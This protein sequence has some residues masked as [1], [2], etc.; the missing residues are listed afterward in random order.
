M[1][2]VSIEF[3][4]FLIITILIY[5]VLPKKAKCVWL[6][7]S[8]YAFYA[9]FDWKY[10]FLLIAITIINYVSGRVLSGH[11]SKAR[12]IL[13]MTIAVN[14][15]ILAFFKY[16]GVGLRIVGISNIFEDLILPVGISFYTFRVIS[17]LVDIYR[18]AEAEKNLVFFAL[19]VS[20]FPTVLEG[21][22]E[23]A[24][25]LI[26]QFRELSR[27]RLFS[28][29]SLFRGTYS[30]IL[31]YFIKMVIADRICFL[32]DAVFNDVVSNGTLMLIS[33]AIAY[34]IQIYTDFL[35]YSLIAMGIARIMGIDLV[36]NFSAP[37]L[38]RSIKDFWGR[39]HI[40]L[41]T[42]LKDYIYIPLGGSRCTK[43]RT[44][45]NLMATF[46]ISGIWHGA[47][48]K[49][50][51]WGFLHGVYQVIGRLLK[52]IKQI[53]YCGGEKEIFRNSGSLGFKILQTVCTFSLVS[54][55]WIFFRVQSLSEGFSFIFR[56]FTN[57]DYQKVAEYGIW[58]ENFELRD[59]V[60]CL[61]GLLIVLVVDIFKY[62]SH[63]TFDELLSHQPSIIRM[64][65]LLLLVG[66]TI[67]FGVYGL[68]TYTQ[69]FV[70][71][72]F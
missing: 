57:W 26:P 14:V 70:Y 25:H 45:F 27:R 68:G 42:W 51:F 62:R 12:I 61:L 21:P 43:F 38:A 1:N 2:F 19:Y 41:S 28:F 54:L 29:E 66:L 8:S 67:A 65:F 40:S 69:P 11:Q 13:W 56:I 58:V 15:L 20:F 6:L 49:F 71:I 16:L 60:I 9:S 63:L 64:G 39:W 24:N 44:Y 23:R 36:D 33:G 18:G 53:F 3:A 46:L 35:A 7:I 50:I 5:Y 55:A 34:S 32:S 37:Y 10:L 59:L 31:G 22:I 4:F 17:Y 47:G 30:I 52:P 72:Q 48:V